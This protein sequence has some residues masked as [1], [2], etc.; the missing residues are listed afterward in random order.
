MIVHFHSNS[1]IVRYN[2]GVNCY[3]LPFNDTSRVLLSKFRSLFNSNIS[4]MKVN[5]PEVM[6]HSALKDF[7]TIL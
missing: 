2:K 4:T 5:I 6:P 3:V 7:N 1:M